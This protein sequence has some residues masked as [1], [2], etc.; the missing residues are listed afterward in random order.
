[1]IRMRKTFKQIVWK[2][3]SGITVIKSGN[4]DMEKALT[5]LKQCKATLRQLKK[6]IETHPDQSETATITWA[7]D[8]SFWGF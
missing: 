8:T 1:M 5:K 3:P 4:S 2:N 7:L 6:T